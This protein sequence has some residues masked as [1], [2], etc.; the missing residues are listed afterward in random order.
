MDPDDVSDFES[1]IRYVRWLMAD[2]LGETEKEPAS[3]RHPTDA[4]ANGWQNGTIEAFL[5][6]AA[7]CAE[8]NARIH[9]E[10]SPSWTQFA[11]FLEGGKTYE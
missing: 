10:P 4:G 7:A 2:R 6:A 11:R 8:D 9:G 1:F 3:P 5:D